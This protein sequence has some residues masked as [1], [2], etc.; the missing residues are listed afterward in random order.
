MILDLPPPPPLFLPNF[1]MPSLPVIPDL[2]G[3]NLNKKEENKVEM[4]SI[5]WNMLDSSKIKNSFW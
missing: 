4:K 5:G 1:Q 3:G 2:G